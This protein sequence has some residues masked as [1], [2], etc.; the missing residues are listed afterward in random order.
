MY[1]RESLNDSNLFSKACEFY[2]CI[3]SIDQ[4]RTNFCNDVVERTLDGL[5]G[6]L[7]SHCINGNTSF[8]MVTLGFSNNFLN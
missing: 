3:V 4:L 2:T 7:G 6:T 1:A 8:N 5:L